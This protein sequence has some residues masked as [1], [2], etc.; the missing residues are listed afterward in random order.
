MKKS[1]SLRVLFATPECA[2]WAKVGGLGEV[3]EGLPAAL[4]EVG[5]DVRVL[6]PGYSSVLEG[7][8]AARRIANLD[9]EYGFPAARL[10]RARL[11]SGVPVLI[12]DCPELYARAGGPYQDEA[13]VDHPDNALRFGFLSRVAALIASD[14][15]PA[16]WRADVLHCNDWP[17][18]LAPA[19][20]ATGMD[21]AGASLMAV[22]NLAFQGNFP[23]ELS[24]SLGLP[25]ALVQAEGVE[26]WGQLS[27]LKGG[28]YYA[29]RIVTVSP[30]YAQEILGEA[31]GCGMQ[32]LLRARAERL[33]G[34]LN[35]IDVRVWDPATDP[36]IRRHY[37]VQSLAN[38]RANKRA[39]QRETGLAA[40]DD[41]L[42][43]GMVT[44]LTD[45][46]GIDFV[47]DALPELLDRKVQLVVLG[48][49]EERF[50][51]ALRAEADAQPER[52]AVVIGFDE[53]LAHRIEAGAD[54]FLMPSRFEPCGLNQM[55]SQRYGTP[56]IVRAVGGL[57]DSVSDFAPA[58]LRAGE[59]TGF[60]FTALTAEDLIAT[61]DRALAVFANTRDWR[62][63]CRNGMRRD[64]SWTASARS[65]E[66]L[67][68]EMHAAAKDA[69]A[70]RAASQQ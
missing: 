69:H 3:S 48:N 42:L 45:Q 62:A 54:A 64:F 68:R 38:K 19:Y 17:T 28:L 47:L 29:D 56:P 32:G 12:L 61:V 6:L 57:A 36:A 40:D 67:Y 22:H 7:A 52:I 2:P 13:G 46:K 31:M 35:G 37:D 51:K 4:H 16:G 15:S 53:G 25:R 60:A 39:L 65:Y 66:K 34:I 24:P 33:C 55:Y 8:H 63:L 27:F 23:L 30:T 44:R 14:L 9:A 5:V 41:A 21:G 26:Y 20:L 59:A 10:L 11:P 58:A 18:A 70:H 43:L 1:R 49:G 50:E